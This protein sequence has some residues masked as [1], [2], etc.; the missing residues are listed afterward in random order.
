MVA[1]R[2][3][4]CVVLASFAVAALVLQPG[5]EHACT[6]EE[7]VGLTIAV[8]DARTGAALC[9]SVVVA[10]DG[11]YREELT[12]FAKLADIPPPCRY[13]GAAER[14]GTYRV[15]ISWSTPAPRTDGSLA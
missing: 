8:R 1:R 4:A 6:Q 5:C 7:R 3:G 14:P 10:F 11:D 13:S 12:N 9:H 2:R 15:E